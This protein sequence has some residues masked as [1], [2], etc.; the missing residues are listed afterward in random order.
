MSNRLFTANGTRYPFTELTNK[1]GHFQQDAYDRLGNV[2]ISTYNIWEIF[3]GYAT[4]LSAFVQIFLYS[5]LKIWSTIHHLRQR[6]QHSFKDRLNVLMSAYEEVPFWWYITL[7]VC[8]LVTMLILIQ[9]Q[10]LYLPWWTYV[11]GVILGG[12]S[13]VPMG[14]IYA[15]SAFHVATGTWNELM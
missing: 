8:C 14:F 13:V 3:F 15:I 1:M 2:Y 5:R 12:M 6:K 9:T 10:D 4:F 11:V 7:F